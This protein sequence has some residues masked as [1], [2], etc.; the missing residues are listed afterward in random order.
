MQINILR[1]ITVQT[2][3]C[4]QFVKITIILQHTSSYIL[5]VLLTHN[6]G[7]HNCTNSHLTFLA[8]STSAGSPKYNVIL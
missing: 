5:Q 4:T 2:N 7:A 8:S 3:E 6:Q 1:I